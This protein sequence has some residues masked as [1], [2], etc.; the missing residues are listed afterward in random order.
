MTWRS[1]RIEESM[2][3][4]NDL[5]SSPVPGRTVVFRGGEVAL[6]PFHAADDIRLRSLLPADHPPMVRNAKGEDEPDPF[7]PGYQVR[8]VERVATRMLAKIAICLDWKDGAGQGWSLAAGTDAMRKW[9][10][11]AYETLRLALTEVEVEELLAAVRAA[12]TRSP[13]EDA[14]KG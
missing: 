11:S 2:L 8:E 6:R 12:G 13:V 14:V 4:I 10:Q 5:L 1:P 9:A 3:T 7:D